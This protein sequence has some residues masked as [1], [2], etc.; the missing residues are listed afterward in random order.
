[1]PDPIRHFYAKRLEQTRKAL[2]ANNFDARVA[3]SADQARSLVLDEILAPMGRVQAGLGGSVSLVQTGIHQALKDLDSVELLDSFDKSL[4]WDEKI[5]LRRR[6]L[7]TDV[8]LT[9]TNAVTE[10]GVLVNL[11]MIG[12]R[13]GALAF[14]PRRVVVVAGRNKLVPDRPAA[15]E[16]VKEYAACVNAA[17]LD[18]KTPCAATGFCHDCSSEDRICNVWT[19]TEKSFPAGRISV[20]LV[21][22]DLGF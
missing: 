19:I 15:E 1:M 12:N 3:E 16:R 10:D 22:E 18:K 14:G 11:D 20:V 8:F 5:E 4:S 7:L 21:N 6:S 2:E 13:V 17:K 9:G